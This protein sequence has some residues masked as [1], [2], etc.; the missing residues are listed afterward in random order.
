MSKANNSAFQDRFREIV[1]EKATQEEIAKI[2]NSSRQN[3]GNWLSG[4]SKPD[5][6]ALAEIAKGYGVSTDY[7]LGLTDSSAVDGD[8]RAF[9]KASGLSDNS[10]N[11]LFG[12]M[13]TEIFNKIFESFIYE[14]LLSILDEISTQSKT[15]L[16]S[17]EQNDLISKLDLDYIDLYR[18]RAHK[19][20]DIILDEFDERSFNLE[21]TKS[22]NNKTTEQQT[23]KWHE[24]GRLKTQHFNASTEEEKAEIMQQKIELYNK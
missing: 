18:Y 20:F 22:I 8:E 12:Q 17:A 2:V 11:V 4:K 3:V 23:Q 21:L 10:A 7:L 14:D 15:W 13:Y 5:I 19:I 1:G 9:C 24:I 6:T 16:N